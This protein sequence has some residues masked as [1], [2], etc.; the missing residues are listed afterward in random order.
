M[1]IE[2]FVSLVGA[3]QVIVV[4][5][6]VG[7]FNRERKHNKI[8]NEKVEK[9]AA[10]RAEESRLAMKLMSANTGLAMVTSLAVKNGKINGEMEQAL[11][12]AKAAQRE[13]YDFINRIAAKQFAVE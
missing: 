7:L 3:G 12:N 10:L 5:V 8:E 13:Y 9:R 11:A 1:P 2:V 4:A 6:I